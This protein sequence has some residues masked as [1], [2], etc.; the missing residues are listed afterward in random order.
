MLHILAFQESSS[1]IQLLE[2][3]QFPKQIDFEIYNLN[4]E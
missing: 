4:G 2:K 1:F 3:Q